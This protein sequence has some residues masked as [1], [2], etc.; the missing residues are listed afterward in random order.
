MSECLAGE[1]ERRRRRPRPRRLPPRER[2][3]GEERPIGHAQP[4][5]DEIAVTTRPASEPGRSTG[6]TRGSGRTRPSPLADAVRRR[7]RPEAASL[8]N[9]RQLLVVVADFARRCDVRHQGGREG[10]Q[11]EVVATTGRQGRDRSPHRR[12][13]GV[14]GVH[15]VA[16]CEV[17]SSGSGRGRRSV[18]TGPRS[19][20]SRSRRRGPSREGG[21]GRAGSASGS[22]CYPVPN[23]RQ[24]RGRLPRSVVQ[25]DARAWR[26]RRSPRRTSHASSPWR[27]R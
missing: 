10:R 11:P 8:G 12:R 27:R 6:S 1:R 20:R 3:V 17:A 14:V 16:Q 5:V 19:R 21:R 22:R 13:R 24:H 7:P 18:A 15:I 2:G 4:P 25:P 26:R 9:G 23:C